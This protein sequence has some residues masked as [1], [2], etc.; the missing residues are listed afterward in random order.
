MSIV[1]Q[2][3]PFEFFADTQ[4]DALDSGYVWIGQPNSD[5]RQYP[6]TVY[7]DA[8]LTIPAPMPLRTSSGYI[9]RNGAPT[10]LYA[11]GNYSILV[12]DKKHQQIYYVADFLMIGSASAAPIGNVERMVSNIAE[13]RALV[14]TAGS[15][16]ATTKG[17]YAPGD[18]GGSSYWLDSLDVS[19]VDNGGTVIVAVDGSRW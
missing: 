17:Y 18:G 8:E 15:T 1:M 19:S 2:I 13:L 16:M 12:E 7:Y 14:V 5:P 9:V 10:F 6:I 4:G 11:G 3:N